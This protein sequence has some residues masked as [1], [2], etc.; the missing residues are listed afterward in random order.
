[1]SVRAPGLRTRHHRLHPEKTWFDARGRGFDSRQLH[2]HAL[3]GSPPSGDSDRGRRL[4]RWVH[5]ADGRTSGFA[6]RPGRL[7]GRRGARGRARAGTQ[8]RRGGPQAPD[9]RPQPAD[10]DEEG[11][12]APGVPAAV[13]GLHAG[14][15]AGGRGGQR[16]RDRRRRHDAGAGRP[17]PVQRGHR[18][19]P[20]GEGRGERR[21]AGPD[22]E[23]HRPRTPRRAGGRDRRR[24]ARAGRRGA[25][26]GR[27]P[28]A[29]GRPDHAGRDPRDRGGR[30]DRGEPPG[31][32][33]DRPGARARTCPWATG[34]AWPT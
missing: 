24:A 32:Q 19:A 26:G 8:R 13:P 31:R 22:D 18:A 21:R 3:A 12:L 15:P 30:A 9:A 34:P 14:H 11:V 17:D 23:D 25:G 33:V 6:C 5:D 2:H 7:S 28:G 29:G 27:Q 10:R 1:M 4:A 16:R 20:G